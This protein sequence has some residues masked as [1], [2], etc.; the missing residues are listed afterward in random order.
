MEKLLK[1]EGTN[2][3]SRLV[4]AQTKI[5]V[6]E[7]GSGSSKTI[8]IIQ[9][10]IAYCEA[11]RN[12]GKRITVARARLTWLKDSVLLDFVQWLVRYGLY[13]I[14]NHNKTEQ[15]YT[16]FG[17]L[18]SFKGL[19]EPQKVH[20]PRQDVLWI[21]EAVEAGVS[22]YNQMAMRT[23]EIIVLDYNPSYT[24]HW[25]YDRVIPRD[26]CTFIHSTLLDNNY[27]PE[28]QRKEILAYNPDIKENKINGTADPVL[29]EIY[30]LG[31]RAQ[32]VGAIYTN[33]SICKTLPEDYKWQVYGLDYGYTNDPTALVRIRYAQGQLWVHQLIYKKGLTNLPLSNNDSKDNIVFHLNLHGVTEEDEV[34]ADSAEPK[35]NDEIA[36]QGF[37]IIG[38][39]KGQDSVKMGIDCV[40]RYKINVTE[41]SM[42]IIDE[43]RNYKWQED[44]K[45][46]K[47]INKP[48]DKF[49][50]AMDAIRYAVTHKVGL[51]TADD[52]DM[53]DGQ[54]V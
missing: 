41:S 20:G 36:S 48:I 11:H 18:I 46:D 35:S 40:K 52:W 24:K 34:I 25:I 7:G 6:L 44:E 8:S 12:N 39:V 10:I 19:D 51:V 26:D 38:A 16:L 22:S 43:L 47:F 4:K 31:K 17:N 33:W 30:G 3:L 5:R 54:L 37:R 28:E 27:L 2:V 9:F 29:W 21:N 14:N 32:V 50:H 15:R 49:N 53:V 45:E 13:D 23:N 1:I 42:F